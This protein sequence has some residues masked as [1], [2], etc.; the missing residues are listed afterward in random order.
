[1]LE[2]IAEQISKEKNELNLLGLKNDYKYLSN[3][4]KPEVQLRLPDITFGE[5]LVLH[6]EIRQAELTC[7]G[8]AHSPGDVLLYLRD[9]KICFAGDL[10]FKHSHPWLGT[11]NSENLIK[12]LEKLLNMDAEIFIP[13]HGD[14]A[15]K[16]DIELEIKYI[17]EILS[18]VEAKK[19][20]G[21]AA[22]TVSLQDLS[23]EFRDWD[24][25]CFLW[26]INY[27][28]KRDKK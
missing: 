20:K 8:T 16:S 10:L 24:G 7:V 18:M 21:E 13:G 22:D 15:A 17:K 14:L 6:G 11:G 25:L 9:E 28:F 3:I 26:N 19:A 5:N 23:P 12:I 2:E 1:V 27:L 4:M